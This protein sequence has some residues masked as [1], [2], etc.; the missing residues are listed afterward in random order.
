MDGK[1]FHYR[2]KCLYNAPDNNSVVLEK[3]NFILE[4]SWNFMCGNLAASVVMCTLPWHIWPQHIE[5]H[6]WV[7]MH[8]MLSACLSSATEYFHKPKYRCMQINLRQN[9]GD[10]MNNQIC[11]GYWIHAKKATSWYLNQWWHKWWTYSYAT[12]V[13]Y[14]SCCNLCMINVCFFAWDPDLKMDT[15]AIC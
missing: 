4:K 7:Y 6:H 5:S 3:C 13:K 1:F 9:I 11:L 10:T 2:K 15:T 14:F 8:S 12:K